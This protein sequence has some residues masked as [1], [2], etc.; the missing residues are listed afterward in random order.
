MLSQYF[1]S[2]ISCFLPPPPPPCRY[3]NGREL[4]VTVRHTGGWIGM[5]F[6]QPPPPRNHRVMIEPPL[7]ISSDFFSTFIDVSGRGPRSQSDNEHNAQKR[8]YL[9]KFVKNN[10]ISYCI[11]IFF[12]LICYLNFSRLMFAKANKD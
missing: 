1:D 8:T 5:N 4:A 3:G 7:P 12:H 11:L 9:L 6:A 2:V 10:A